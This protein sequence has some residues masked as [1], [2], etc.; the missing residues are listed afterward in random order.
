M[1]SVVTSISGET[2]VDG[3][4]PDISVIVPVYNAR[5]TLSRCVE[6]L[7]AQTYPDFEILLVDDG[8]TDA[9]LEICRGFADSDPRVKVFSKPNGGVSSARNLGLDSARGK[10]IAFCDSDDCAGKDWLMSMRKEAGESGMVMCG[11]HIHYADPEKGLTE[12]NIGMPTDRPVVMSDMTEILEKTL[13]ARLLSFIWNKLFVRAEIENARLRFDETCRIFEDEIFVLSYLEAVRQVV[14]VPCYGY[15]YFFPAGFY[16]KYGFETDAFM[17][18][19]GC[20]YR[21]AGQGASGGRKYPELPSIIYWY[22]IAVV[23]YAA[24]HPF[25]E[26]ADRIRMLKKVAE[27]FHSGPFNHLTVRILPERILYMMLKRRGKSRKGR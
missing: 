16:T 26:C 3:R 17:K 9:S 12:E 11:Y 22:K 20:I 19:L 8:S 25:A 2:A 27:D 23:R 18:V 15:S 6:S 10:Y 14:Y 5:K 4:H 1:G 21:L 7:L 24:A 13:N